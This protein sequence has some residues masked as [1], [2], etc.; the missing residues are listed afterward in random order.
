MMESVCNHL[1][2]KSTQSLWA[3]LLH[4][5][6]ELNLSGRTDYN[7]LK[8]C[9]RFTFSWGHSKKDLY[10]T[11]SLS[12]DRECHPHCTEDVSVVFFPL[13]SNCNCNCREQVSL[14]IKK[15]ILPH[16]YASFLSNNYPPPSLFLPR[17][18]CSKSNAI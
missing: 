5:N 13:R 6:R 18:T 8:T 12:T 10:L 11:F 9:L 1:L 15:K 16:D 7:P 17:R 3:F 2:G 14:R 4:Q